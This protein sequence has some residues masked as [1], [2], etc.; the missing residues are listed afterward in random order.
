M[1]EQILY[2]LEVAP[3]MI[4]PLARSPFFS[5]ASDTPVP[6]GSLISISFGKQ[7]GE[8]IVYDSQ[9]LPGR[10]PIW[11]KYI[12]SVAVPNFLT[13][14][15]C[16]LALV[17]S[18]EYFT[19]LGKV[20]KHFLPKRVKERTTK[21]MVSNQEKILILRPTKVERTVLE[22]PL[23]KEQKHSL[24]LDTSLEKERGRLL[25]LITKQVYQSKQQTLII[26][27]EITLLPLLRRTLCRYFPLDAIAALH[28]KL[29]DGAYFTAWERIRS[30]EA[31]IIIGT[32]QGLFAPFQ[33][34][35][36]IIVTEEQDE[37]Y[38]QWDMSPRYHGKRVAEFLASIHKTTLLFTSGTPSSETLAR[39]EN[40]HLLPLHPLPNHPPVGDRLSII[41]LRLERYRKNY[42]PLSHELIQRIDEALTRREQILLYINR[43]G[44]S[45]FSVCERCKEVFRCKECEHPLVNTEDGGF[46]CLNCR[47]KTGSFPSCPSCGH[48]VF[49]HVGFGTE[50]I[51]R[52]IEKRFPSARVARLDSTTQKVSGALEKLMEN[53]LAGSVD[54]LI[55][56]QMALKNPPLPNLSLVAMIDADSLLLFPDF[57]A[58]ERLFR[59]ISRALRQTEATT[60]GR[61][62]V[63]TFHPEHTFFQKI[64]TDGSTLFLQ[65]LI[66]ERRDLSY[67]PFARFMSLSVS[68]KTATEAE[69][70]AEKLRVSLKPYLDGLRMYPRKPVD[71]QIKRGL[72]ES[73]ILIRFSDSLPPA[74][75]TFLQKNSKDCII[76]IDP[77]SLR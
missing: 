13:E 44:L 34:L 69:K 20:L 32:R 25:S 51:E 16:E 40:K 15:Q 7:M 66:A 30:G 33:N 35:G 60:H 64:V 67:P 37:S 8:G 61:V 48:L 72:F 5:Y 46:H 24:F 3:L 76:D 6:K 75:R 43:Q 77:L 18:H 71:R 45:A 23:L 57:Q 53:G 10:K 29:S 2:R 73:Q 14:E 74:L 49:R 11:M 28:S 56:T 1:K 22:N 17:V 50:K 27:P 68:G 36:L 55:G 42:S 63:Q 21:K 41:N 59:D 31:K 19:P 38:K 9:I 70:K 26:V 52:E 39:I 47:Y 62:I 4:L 12:E 65:K 54:I 58:D